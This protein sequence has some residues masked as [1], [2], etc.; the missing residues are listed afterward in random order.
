MLKYNIDAEN[1]LHQ[2]WWD[3]VSKTRRNS[4]NVAKKMKRKM[5]QSSDNEG[6]SKEASSSTRKLLQETSTSTEVTPFIISTD[7]VREMIESNATLSS[8]LHKVL[9][10][11]YKVYDIALEAHNKQCKILSGKFH[12]VGY[13][14]IR[15][16]CTLLDTV[17]CILCICYLYFQP[18]HTSY[19]LGFVLQ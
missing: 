5:Q 7:N 13:I 11:E 18:M 14:N 2:H 4:V 15:I 16:H 10:L 6:D 1:S 17:M 9:S 19:K 8:E 3:D 12:M